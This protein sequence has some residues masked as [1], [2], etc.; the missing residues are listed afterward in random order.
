[1][2]KIKRPHVE[3]VDDP[4]LREWIYILER[5]V[6]RSWP[7]YDVRREAYV[8][9]ACGCETPDHHIDCQFCPILAQIQRAHGMIPTP[10]CSSIPEEE[11]KA[12][13]Q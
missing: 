4:H 11:E 5:T 9:N 2:T 1:M 6:L 13:V 10:C 8:C 7:E 3:G 12:D